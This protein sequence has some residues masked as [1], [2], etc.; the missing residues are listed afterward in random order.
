MV[1]AAANGPLTHMAVAEILAAFGGV[2]LGVVLR[3]TLGG[4]E[5]R[6]SV[7]GPTRQQSVSTRT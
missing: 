3:R 5:K 2:M 6:T 4:S 7:S 1:T